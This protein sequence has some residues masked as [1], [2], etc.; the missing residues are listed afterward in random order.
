MQ[1]AELHDVKLLVYAIAIAHGHLV[2]IADFLVDVTYIVLGRE[3]GVYMPLEVCN[4]V[5][6]LEQDGLGW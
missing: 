2:V 6:A 3:Y 5:A 1:F 4:V